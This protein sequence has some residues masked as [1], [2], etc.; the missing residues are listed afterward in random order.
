MRDI[1]TLLDQA[2][3]LGDVK[4]VSGGLVQAADI[5]REVLK[6]QEPEDSNVPRFATEVLERLLAAHAVHKEMHALSAFRRAQT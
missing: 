5:I 6:D 2:F 1:A 4:G 3:E